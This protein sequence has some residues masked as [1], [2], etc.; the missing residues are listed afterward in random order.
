[1]ADKIVPSK[2][3]MVKVV[4]RAPVQVSHQGKIYESGQ[5]VEVPKALAQFWI[6]SEWV[7]EV[8]EPE[9]SATKAA[10]SPAKATPKTR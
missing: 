1:M 9:T 3:V 4:V 8:T 10:T 7:D 6:R 2:P 5:T